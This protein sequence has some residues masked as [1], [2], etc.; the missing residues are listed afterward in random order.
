MKKILLTLSFFVAAISSISAQTDRLTLL[1]KQTNK[2]KNSL[3]KAGTTTTLLD[4]IVSVNQKTLF[5]Y[6]DLGQQTSEISFDLKSGGGN[7]FETT[8]NSDGKEIE[9]SYKFDVATQ[10]YNNLRK[11]EYTY[12]SNGKLSSTINY[13]WDTSTNEWAF[14]YKY[15]F[16]YDSNGKQ[17]SRSGYTRDISTNTWVLELKLEYIY[18]SN[19]NQILWDGDIWDSSTSIW[20]NDTKIEYT[21]DNTGALTLYSIYSWD[22]S[23]DKWVNILKEEYTYDS[24]ENQTLKISY[25]WDSSSNNW[26]ESGKQEYTFNS[27]KNIATESSSYTDSSNNWG[28][29]TVSTY[30]YTTKTVSIA[31]ATTVDFSVYPNPATTQL[32]INNNGFIIEKITIIDVKGVVVKSMIGNI[33]TIAV[34]DLSNGLY[35][36]QIATSEGLMHSRFVKQ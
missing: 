27:N 10:T 14:N 4:S 1:K 15:E 16:S 33:A 5:T 7:K 28:T 19:G 22:R 2:Q 18:D 34:N 20:V 32:S 26:V 6:N 21:Y 24:N 25:S 13:N 31:E 8:Y 9:T 12:D 29:P 23:A 35:F 30:Y 3:S 11:S 17:E 36:I